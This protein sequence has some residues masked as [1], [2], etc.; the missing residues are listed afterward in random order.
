MIWTVGRLGSREL[1][2]GPL[3]L[4]LPVSTAER[5]IGKILDGANFVQSDCFALM[6]LA[7]KTGDRYRDISESIRKEVLDVLQSQPHFSV[8][9]RET[10][11]L[12]TKDQ[13]M[14]FG[15]SL[16]IGLKITT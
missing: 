5:W 9:V 16:P 2:H 15:E 4:V 6:L 10:E 7:R 13:G 12:N 1:L 14:L 11:Q 3:N 8:L